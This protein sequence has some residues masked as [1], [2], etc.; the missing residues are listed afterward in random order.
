MRKTVFFSYAREDRETAKRLFEDLALYGFSPWHDE[1][2]LLAG[3]AWREVI[4]R[5]I[6]ASDHVLI[7]MSTRST[8]KQGF[9][10]VEQK[11]ALEIAKEFPVS[12]IFVIPVRLDDREIPF[13]LPGVLSLYGSFP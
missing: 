6:R 3:Q 5:K 12:Y 8:S 9:V 4:P 2:N 11:L 13:N 7:L 10:Q 1:E